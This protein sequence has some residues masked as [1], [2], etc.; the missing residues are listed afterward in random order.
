MKLLK[1]HIL[2][3]KPYQDYFED[4]NMIRDYITVKNVI[5]HFNQTKN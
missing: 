2:Q 1:K 4:Q 5:V 3:Q